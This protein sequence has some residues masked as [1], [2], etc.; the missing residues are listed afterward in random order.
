MAGETEDAALVAEVNQILDRVWGHPR[1]DLK[2][3]LVPE[4]AL[5][6]LDAFGVPYFYD[7]EFNDPTETE[8]DFLIDDLP[9]EE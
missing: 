8:L 4:T 7:Q 3:V 2:G 5:D 9:S 1:L 6:I